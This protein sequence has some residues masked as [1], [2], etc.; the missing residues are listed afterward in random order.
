MSIPVNDYTKYVLT[1]M[2]R[3]ATG[4]T[5]RPNSSRVKAPRRLGDPFGFGAVGEDNLPPRDWPI[6][7]PIQEGPGKAGV[8]CSAVHHEGDR[9]WAGRP[10][11]RL[12]LC[13]Y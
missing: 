3:F 9:L 12:D 10:I 13:G 1:G 8:S 7:E 5:P 6:T 11:G 4:S 2:R